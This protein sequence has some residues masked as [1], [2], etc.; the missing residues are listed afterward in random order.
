MSHPTRRFLLAVGLAL[1]LDGIACAAPEGDAARRAA[2]E[3]MVTRYRAAYPDVPELGVA[4]YQA[5]AASAE[6]L[7]VDVRPPAERAVS[8]L[9]GAIP[10]GAVEADPASFAGRILVTYCTIGYRSGQAAQA[11][12][13]AGL[14]ARNLRGSVLAWTH[15]GGALVGPDGPTRR[16]H[17]YGRRWDLVAEGYEAVW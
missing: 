5:L 17:V 7:L 9:P 14:D 2:I 11:L 16:V 6:V 4:D 15:A 8:I 3:A 13:E 1:G 10:L 12:R